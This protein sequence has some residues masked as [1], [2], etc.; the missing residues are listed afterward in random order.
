MRAVRPQTGHP[1]NAWIV[2]FVTYTSNFD[3][4]LQAFKCSDMTYMLDVDVD[5]QITGLLD[6]QLHVELRFAS[7]DLCLLLRAYISHHQTTEQG[8][9]ISSHH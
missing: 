4:F 5:V 2:H 9:D 1:Q 7:Y 8:Y 6:V 3:P